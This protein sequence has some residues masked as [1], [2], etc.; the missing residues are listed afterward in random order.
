MSPASPAGFAFRTKLIVGP[1]RSLPFREQVATLEEANGIRVLIQSSRSDV[2]LSD[3]GECAV[4]GQSY[5]TVEDSEQAAHHWRGRLTRVFASLGITADFGDRAGSLGGA[6]QMELDRMAEVAG[7]PVMDDRWGHVVYPADQVPLFFGASARATVGVSEEQL[8]LALADEASHE[9]VTPRHRLAYDLLALSS[10]ISDRPDARLTVLMMAM[11]A[12]AET[13]FREEATIDHI[14]M[15]LD[16]TTAAELNA[17]ERANLTNALRSLKRESGRRAGQR[18]ASEMSGRLYDGMGPADFYKACYTMR[19]AVVHARLSRPSR[20]DVARSGAVLAQLVS[21][22][23][24][25]RSLVDRVV[26]G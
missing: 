15:L 25:G 23:V 17:E 26:P 13:R 11:E 24:A 10:F 4:M 12:L 1:G 6:A 3:A 14:N 22:L 20:E 5:A 9:E 21:H 16:I 19:N 7:R 8:R 18:L 2:M